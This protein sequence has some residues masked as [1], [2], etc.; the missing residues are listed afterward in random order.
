MANKVVRY[1]S[2]S[3]EKEVVTVR[4]VSKDTIIESKQYGNILV[5]EGNY[6]LK[7]ADKTE[8]GITE[9]DLNAQYEQ[10]ES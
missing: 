9:A 3:N 10:K 4:Q 5:T 6:I 1:V 7:S 8:V 2:K